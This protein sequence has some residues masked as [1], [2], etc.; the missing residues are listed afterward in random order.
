[1]CYIFF[2]ENMKL[3]YLKGHLLLEDKNNFDQYVHIACKQLY[4]DGLIGYK[5][6]KKRKKDL[7]MSLARVV[8]IKSKLLRCLSI[9]NYEK[10]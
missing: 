10:S 6:L 7:K 1:M 5:F 3:P 2:L 9:I 8:G 4:L